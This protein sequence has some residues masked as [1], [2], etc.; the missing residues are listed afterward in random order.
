MNDHIL[1]DTMSPALLLRRLLLLQFVM[2]EPFPTFLSPYQIYDYDSEDS[3]F[4]GNTDTD[5]SNDMRKE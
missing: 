4:I 3:D 5:G 1:A 2:N